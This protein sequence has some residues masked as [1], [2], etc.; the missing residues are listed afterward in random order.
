MDI[1]ECKYGF[2][3]CSNLIKELHCKE[4]C[5]TC[6]EGQNYQHKDNFKSVIKETE[7]PE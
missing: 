3:T 7:K 4:F 1:S 6:E 2:S 5:T